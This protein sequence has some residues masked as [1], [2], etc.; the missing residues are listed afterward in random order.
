MIEYIALG[1]GFL[2]ILYL[3]WEHFE[4]ARLRR[5]FHHII[6]VNG[7]RGKS[8]VARLIGHGLRGNGLRTFTKVTGT[9]PAIIDPDG[10]EKIVKRLGPANIREQIRTMRWA[11]KAM[12]DVLV[13]ECMAIKKEYQALTQEK[14]LKA[15][16]TV[17]TNVRADHQEEFTADKEKIAASLAKTIPFLGKLVVNE[18]TK[19]YFTEYA[20]SQGAEVI[21]AQ[22]GI[23]ANNVDFFDENIALAVKAMELFDIPFKKA[24][25]SL[26]GYPRDIGAVSIYRHDNG[27]YVNAFSVNDAES[28][29]ETYQ[30]TLITV[31]DKPL[32][33]V[34]NNRSDRPLRAREHLNLIKQLT[35]K[36][37]FVAGGF[38]GYFKKNLPR[39][40][41]K[42]YNN[43]TELNQE[44]VFG[45][46]N[47]YRKGYQII[48]YFQKKGNKIYG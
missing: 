5:S 19:P 35:P 44:F 28:L 11:K 25:D 29:L 45:M 15:D 21:V 30:K 12:A 9:M 10:N 13:I 1:L 31:G 32:T 48:N 40:E 24:L 41:V 4:I 7:I 16:I 39:V 38:Y 26:S 37:V 33:I 43:E 46:G 20:L 34:I 47:I 18:E 14:I 22:N 8:T 3:V 36:T 23:T 42:R 27:F 17:I 2:Y 6:H